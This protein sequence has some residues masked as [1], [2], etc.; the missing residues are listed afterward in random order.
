MA[1]GNAPTVNRKKL[2]NYMRGY[3]HSS[4]LRA[5]IELGVY[6][7]LA[8]GPADQATLSERLGTHPRGTRILLNALSVL[9]LVETDGKT[10]WLPEGAKELLVS[11]GT[12]YFGAPIRL[13]IGDWE[14][15]AHKRLADAVRA[16]GPV[17]DTSA[18]TPDFDYFGEWAQ[19]SAE[20]SFN[21]GAAELVADQLL[22][23]RPE[24]DRIDVLDI[25]CGSGTYGY[26]VAMRDP[27]VHVTESDWSQ[28]AL[29][30]AE[31]NAEKLGLADR[32]SFLRA[33][34]FADPLGGPYDLVT[35]A[36]VL[37]HRSADQAA[38]ALRR[39]FDVVKPGGKIGVVGHTFQEGVP[40]IQDP[41]PH[42]FSLIMLIQTS[43]GEAHSVA[44]YERMFADAGFVN[45]EFH[46]S[47]NSMHRAMVA[48]R[49]A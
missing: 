7:A 6:D 19:H 17:V 33:D 26:T 36:H 13:G 46:A 49:P 37:H 44:T 15:D 45:L 16:G 1:E 23:Y 21:T 42:M 28:Q 30:V 9:E 29:D 11:T 12:D 41:N 8:D 10:Y 31:K 35:M 24:Q 22:P 4:L 40:P 38:S 34:A 18:D 2:H 32:A 25:G 27:R 20:S 3:T 47:K 48:E 43:G 39:V 14:W 5:S